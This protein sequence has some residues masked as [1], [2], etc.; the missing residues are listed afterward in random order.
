MNSRQK[1]V[2]SFISLLFLLLTC[3]TTT[4]AWTISNSNVYLSKIEVEI[5]TGDG[6]LVSIKPN[7]GFKSTISEEEIKESIVIKYL[8][9]KYVD[10]LLV[11][12][13]NKRVDLTSEQVTSYFSQIKLETSTSLDGVNFKDFN[14]QS[15]EASGGKLVSFDLYFEALENEYENEETNIFFNYS[16]FNYDETNKL[17]K[18]TRLLTDEYDKITTTSDTT[19]ANYLKADLTTVDANGDSKVISSATEGFEIYAANAARFSTT[20]VEFNEEVT[21][22]YEPNIGLGSYASDLDS[23]KYKNSNMYLE[24]SYLDKSKSASFTYLTNINNGLEVERAKLSVDEIP[25]TYKD[26]YTYEADHILSIKKGQTK[27]VNFCV[28]LE[29]RDADCFDAIIGSSVRIDLAFT[30]KSQTMYEKLKTINYH[31]FDQT[32]SLSYYDYDKFNVYLPL[33]GGNAEFY[34]WYT[35]ETYTTLFD[36]TSVIDSLNTNFD[37]YAKWI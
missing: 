12:E 6:I 20:C 23:S 29:G 1:T 8:G 24:A 11:D 3:V 37:V 28:W 34:G 5:S 13:N 9:Y 17:I 31:S 16:R 35:D 19:K 26:F 33:N 27:S 7:T 36:F 22:I 18:Q 30:T 4:F 21:K 15:A 2:V 10:D 32:F 25:F 14:G